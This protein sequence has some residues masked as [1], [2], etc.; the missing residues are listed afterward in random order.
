M[1]AARGT[2]AILALVAL[3]ASPNI[4]YAMMSNRGYCE[5]HS[6]TWSGTD[7]TN[8]V[9]TVVYQKRS[10]CTGVGGTIQTK[11]SASACSL[12]GP[13]L[14][15]WVSAGKTLPIPKCPPQC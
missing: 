12:S 6:G 3:C 7:D 14:T 15:K 5:L 2:V 13:A 4:A 8:G 10:D 1:I 9:C 11:G